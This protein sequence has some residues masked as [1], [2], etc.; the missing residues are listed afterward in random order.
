M[1]KKISYCELCEMVK[2]RNAPEVIRINQ[3]DEFKYTFNDYDYERITNT[4]KAKT[5]HLEWNY[6]ALCRDKIIIEVCLPDILNEKEKTYLRSI[7]EPFRDQVKSIRKFRFTDF[8]FIEIL[9][10]P[11]SEC[12]DDVTCSMM[13]PSYE[14]AKYYKNMKPG[15]Q[16]TL[17]E[18]EL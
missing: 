16:Y 2:A 14:I 8:E 18:L 13:F 17:E 3:L 11:Y 12:L 9:H 4:G 7:I 1:N 15:K 6:G 5:L 10:T